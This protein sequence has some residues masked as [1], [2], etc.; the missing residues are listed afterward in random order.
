MSSMRG[1][2]TPVRQRRRRVFKEVANLAY[3]STNLKDD[4]EALPYK[5]VDYE[6]S[7]FW[8][9]VYRDRA[10]IRERIRLA[11]GMSLR[12]EN[13]EHPGHLTQ[14][15]EESNIDEKYYEPPLM[16][17]IPSACNE[18]KE[19]AFIVG[20]QCQGC[21]AHPCME[22]CPKKAISFKDG[23]SYI[24]QEKCI[25]CGQC[26]KVCPYGAIY[27]RKR[28]C[29]NACGVG[30]IET[31]YAGRAKINPDKCVSCGMCMVNCPF[32][33]IADK[34]QIYQLIKAM[35][36]GAE[37]IAILAPA[38]VGQ[39]G[40]KATPNKIKAALLDIGFADVWEVAVGADAG[41]LEEAKHYVQ[42]V[43]TGK[44]PFLLTSCCPS[45]SML[46]KKYFP[47]VIDE[48]SNA[49]TPM[50]ATARAAR[51]TSPNAKIVFVGPCVRSIQ[52]DSAK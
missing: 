41:A 12:P 52:T 51:I 48:I 6:E 23:Y 10:I 30:A 18:C 34:S 45:W 26:K 49:L 38:F 37:V 7:E 9:S 2:D 27:E 46:G 47:E 22:V 43:A 14:G 5:I 8:E 21:M 31:D 44:L 19:K 16:Q 32:G 25:K 28:P 11:M 3:N 42:S 35:N 29:A 24:D 17:V 39:F 33:A 50:V 20:E 40:P 15:L 1:I 13:R 36:E 4:M